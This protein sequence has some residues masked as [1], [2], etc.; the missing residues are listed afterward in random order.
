MHAVWNGHL[1]C[2]K[3]LCV[4]QNG[5]DKLGQR[6][7]S[8]NMASTAGYAGSGNPLALQVVSSKNSGVAQCCWSQLCISL[9]C[10]AP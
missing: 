8:I 5:R 10:T 3:V 2:V 6:S 9:R 1:E 4:N 7:R